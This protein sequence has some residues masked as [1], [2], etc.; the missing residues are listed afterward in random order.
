MRVEDVKK[1]RIE[2]Q[3]KDMEECIMFYRV[4]LLD[5]ISSELH[6]TS[7]V[8]LAV[9]KT[10]DRMVR[11]MFM[12]DETEKTIRENDEIAEKVTEDVKERIGKRAMFDI[13]MAVQIINTLHDALDE[14]IKA[15]GH[16]NVFN[17][18]LVPYTIY[19]DLT[20]LNVTRL[21][22]SLPKQYIEEFE[23]GQEY[24]SRQIYDRYFVKLK[25]D[26]TCKRLTFLANLM[27]LLTILSE[28]LSF[29]LANS[30]KEQVLKYGG[31]S[32]GEKPSD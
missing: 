9:L 17:L 29:K 3:P 24:F 20:K 19:I 18:I 22:A 32:V 31:I 15:L 30:V 8:T 13:G 25:K 4:S 21:V 27:G 7:E 12:V 6:R 14:T 5:F 16:G 10:M 2:F 26:T 23:E 1:R 11:E 28:A